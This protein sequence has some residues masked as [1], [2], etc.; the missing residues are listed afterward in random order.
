MKLDLK[1]GRIA[2]IYYC[3]LAICSLVLSQ[4]FFFFLY[5]RPKMATIKSS[6]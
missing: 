3:H 4:L 2:S 1:E 6:C 5:K